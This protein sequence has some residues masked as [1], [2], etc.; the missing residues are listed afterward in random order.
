MKK[1]IISVL[2]L[3]ILVTLGCEDKDDKAVA[4]FSDIYYQILIIREKY[5]DTTE[6]NPKVKELLKKYDYTMTTFQNK[7]FELFEQDRAL[8][9]RMIDSLRKKAETS[10]EKNSK[11]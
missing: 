11:K 10:L 3:L 9:T 2:F 7:S 1:T 8:F 6:G 5:P 4:S